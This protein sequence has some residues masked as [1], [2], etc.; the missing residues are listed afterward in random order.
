MYR[1]SLRNPA[2]HVRRSTA[3]RDDDEIGVGA[4]HGQVSLQALFEERIY[5]FEST[6]L[7]K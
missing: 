1:V 5:N 7:N 2:R 6:V 3:G 4:N